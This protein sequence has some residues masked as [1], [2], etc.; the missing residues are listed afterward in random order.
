MSEPSAKGRH[1][2]IMYAT[3]WCGYCERARR[4]F[5]LKGIDFDEIDVE[6]SPEARREMLARSGRRSVPQIF[7]GDVH[8]GGSHDLLAL[9]AAGKLDTLLYHQE[10]SS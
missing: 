1:K 7:I 4:L 3:M 6:S 10:R 8:I 2:V 9:E 5:R